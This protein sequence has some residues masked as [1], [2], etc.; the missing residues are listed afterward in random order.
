MHCALDIGKRGGKFMRVALIDVDGHNFP[1]N[2][3]KSKVVENDGVYSCPFCGSKK[4]N[5]CTQ[6]VLIKT[7]DANTGKEV[8]EHTNK[9]RKLTNREKAMEYDNA[10]TDGVGCWHY[11]CRKCG[12]QSDIYTE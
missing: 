11:S 6:A 4:I 10:T 2:E 1:M 9:I 5:L 12:W 3:R 8:D 7:E